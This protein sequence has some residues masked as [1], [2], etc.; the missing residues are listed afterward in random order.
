MGLANGC[1][2]TLCAA[3][4]VACVN[5]A[6]DDMI[7]LRADEEDGEVGEEVWGWE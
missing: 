5:C 6:K 2:R 7:A 4:R 3:K 1:E